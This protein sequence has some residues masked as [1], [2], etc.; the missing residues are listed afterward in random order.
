MPSV[1][2]LHRDTNASIT[3]TD[4]LAVVDATAASS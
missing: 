4:V 2:V 3:T 1:N